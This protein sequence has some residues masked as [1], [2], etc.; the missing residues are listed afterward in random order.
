[1][2]SAASFRSKKSQLDGQSLRSIVPKQEV[3]EEQAEKDID[4]IEPQVEVEA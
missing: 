1:M 4:E 3:P 2:K